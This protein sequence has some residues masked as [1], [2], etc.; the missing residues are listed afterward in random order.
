M[1]KT[2]L[3][4]IAKCENPYIGEWLDH[5]LSMGFDLIVVADND[6]KMELSGFSSSPTPRHRRK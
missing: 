5:H 3:I 6:D 4:A 1:M 2:A